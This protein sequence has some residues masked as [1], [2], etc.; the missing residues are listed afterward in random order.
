MYAP[1]STTLLRL[2]AGSTDTPAMTTREDVDLMTVP[3]PIMDV[4]TVVRGSLRAVAQNKA[5]Y[6]PGLMNRIVV[7]SIGRRLLTRGMSVAI[8]GK[9]MSRCAPERLMLRP[10]D[11]KR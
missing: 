8:Q 4:E 3:M 7:G 10:K 1:R 5:V 6:I 2:V 9:F 11:T